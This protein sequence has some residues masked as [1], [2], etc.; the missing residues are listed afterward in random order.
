MQL[1]HRFFIKENI[2]F[3]FG[4]NVFNV[5]NQAA[6]LDRSVAL[7]RANTPSIVNEY[8]APAAVLRYGTATN[9]LSQ[10]YNIMRNTIANYQTQH[11]ATLA[12]FKN[13]F[14]NLPILFQGPRT[15]RLSLGVQF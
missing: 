3:K 10:S 14:Y 12:T 8:N 5:L 7:I 13:P 9:T 2:A 4:V 1:T 11:A 15:I 6:E